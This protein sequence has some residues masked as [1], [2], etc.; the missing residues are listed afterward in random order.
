MQCIVPFGFFVW[1]D[2]FRHFH[3]TSCVLFC[4]CL[5]SL[6]NILFKIVRNKFFLINAKIPYE[7][8][9]TIIIAHVTQVKTTPKY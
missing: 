5:P 8:C 2:H 6:L 9:D 7:L 1:L 3:K 4:T